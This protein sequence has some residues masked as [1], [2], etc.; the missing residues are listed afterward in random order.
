MIAATGRQANFHLLGRRDDMHRLHAALDVLVLS[1][2]DGEAL[3]VVIMEAMACG[4][5]CVAT[6]VGD[7]ALVIGEAGKTVP[8]RSPGALA[9]GI[10]ALLALPPAQYAALSAAARQRAQERFTVQFAAYQSVW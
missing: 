1:A 5:P 3:P 6:D 9:E 2:S 7:T 4:V 8:P 10:R